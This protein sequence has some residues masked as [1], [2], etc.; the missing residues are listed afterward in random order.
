MSS[1]LAK[2]SEFQYL[3]AVT[4][5]GEIV[6]LVGMRPPGPE[7]LAFA[8]TEKPAEMINAYVDPR[9]RKGG[10]IG[11]FLVQELERLARAGGFTEMILNSGPRYR[12][13]GWEFFDRMGYQRRGLTLNLY[14]KGLHAPVWSKVLEGTTQADSPQ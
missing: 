8:V 14:G 6:G 2:G 11:S 12:Q 5:D 7:M 10:G 4:S 13:S 3:V 9:H 1:S